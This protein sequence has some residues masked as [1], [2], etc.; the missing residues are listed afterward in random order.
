MLRIG[1]GALQLEGFDLD[2]TDFD[3]DALVELTTG[4][5]P[6]S[7]GQANGGAVPEVSETP[8][9]RPGDI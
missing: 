9:P 5:E 7:E 8:I 2:I 6:D 4:D 3:A 1:L